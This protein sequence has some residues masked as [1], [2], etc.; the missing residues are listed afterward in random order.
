MNRPSTLSVNEP[1]TSRQSFTPPSINEPPA[2]PEIGEGEPRVPILSQVQ[3]AVAVIGGADL[4]LQCIGSNFTPAAYITFNGGQEPTEWVS[5]TE[6]TTIVKPST[7]TTPGEYPVTVVTPF[8]ETEPQLFEFQPA[9]ET[10]ARE[11]GWG[12]PDEMEEELELAREEGDYATVGVR[13]TTVVK[14]KK[15]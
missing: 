3:P 4:I 9:E 12:D 8:G 11:S 5:D 14:V 2:L 6:V 15:K 7:A 10:G 13:K 1:Q